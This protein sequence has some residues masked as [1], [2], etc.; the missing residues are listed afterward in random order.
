M[1]PYELWWIHWRNCRGSTESLK[2]HGVSAAIEEHAL[3]YSVQSASQ[4]VPWS[5]I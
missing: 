4:Q 1:I 3:S 2:T 5:V